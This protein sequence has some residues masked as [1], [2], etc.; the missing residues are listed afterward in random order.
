MKIAVCAMAP[1]IESLVDVRFGR[2]P[3]FIIAEVEDGKIKKW[4][5]LPNPALNAFGGAGIQAAQAIARKGV[6]V[7]ICGS[8]GPNAY[9]V[10][11]STGI[12]LIPGISGITVRQAI[13]KYLKGELKP[14]FSIGPRGFG[15][16]RGFGRKWRWRGGRGNW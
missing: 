5:S 7:L 15:Y 4:E 13:E 8:L 6:N 2:C 9:G 12:Q 1:D 11:S 16:G 10:L 14:D 3:Y